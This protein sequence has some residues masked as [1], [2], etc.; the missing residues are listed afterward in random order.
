ML[1]GLVLGMNTV[2]VV[3][4]AEDIRRIP[5]AESQGY[6]QYGGDVYGSGTHFPSYYH[7]ADSPEQC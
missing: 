4:S 7:Q 5:F 2:W 3:G 6:L 1:T